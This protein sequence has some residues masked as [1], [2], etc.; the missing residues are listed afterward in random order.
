MLISLGSRFCFLWS[1]TFAPVL[2]FSRQ[3]KSQIERAIAK[4]TEQ[5]QRTFD[6]QDDGWDDYSS[7]NDAEGW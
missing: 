6:D 5:T 2:I 1:Q 7:E 4:F 3:A